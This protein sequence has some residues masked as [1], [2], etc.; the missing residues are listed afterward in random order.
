MM[1]PSDK[2]TTT[3]RPLSIRFMIVSLLA[4]ILSVITIAAGALYIGLE[5]DA[6]MSH[7]YGSHSIIFLCFAVTYLIDF[8]VARLQKPRTLPLQTA[9]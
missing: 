2:T 3:N 6:Y 7:W 1:N 5:F 4:C 9:S 8:G